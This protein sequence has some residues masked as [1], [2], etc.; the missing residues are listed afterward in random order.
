MKKIRAV[1]AILICIPVVLL[2]SCK[3]NYNGAELKIGVS[4][5]QGVFNPF[6]AE[7]EADRQVVSQMFKSIQ[8]KNGNN[9]L[10][11]YGGGI[12]YEFVG[13]TQVKYT[14]SINENLRFSNGKNV[15]IDDVIFFYHFIADAT[16]DGTY[17]D[18]YLN[19]IVGLKEYYFDDKNYQSSISDIESRIN[20]NYTLTTIETDDYVDYLVATRLE[21]KFNGKLDSASPYGVTWEEY[22]KSHG[23]S[24]AISDLGGNPSSGNVVKLV[25]T[26]E[27]E[28]NPLSYNPEDWYRQKLYSEYI[29]KNYANGIDVE[30]I[31]GIKKV[32]DYTC[33]VLFNSRNINALA[34][35]NALLVSK[36]YLGVEYIKGAAD[37]IKEMNGYDV[38]SGSYIVTEYAD[39][40]VSMVSSN[41]SG[42]GLCEFSNLK[43]VEMSENDD[44]VKLVTSGKIDVAQ[45]LATAKTINSLSNKN[46]KYF[47]E[48]KDSYVSLFLNTRKLDPSARKAL[49]GL[50]NVNNAVEK[51]IG[52]YYTRPLRPISVRFEE[53]PSDVTSPYYSESA[54]TV[55]NMGSG[56][57]VSQVSV[58]CCCDE[59]DLEYIALTAY[60]EILSQKGITLNIVIA[61]KTELEN[62]V[63]AG[64]ADMWVESVSDGDSCDKYNYYNSSGSFNKT[65]IGTPEINTLTQSIRS[66][67]GFSD[68]IKMTAQLMELVMEQAVECPLY[69]LQTVTLYNTE[70]INEDSLNQNA[71]IDGYA[72]YIPFLKKN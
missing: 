27:A 50:C 22:L 7:S 72:Y 42:E 59:K 41:F 10:I 4:G 68:K 28:T 8:Y 14:V 67:V 64:K 13:D 32:N 34:Q 30:S 23:Y 26:A 5:L 24:E 56:T 55:Y 51:E 66:A 40:V 63:I 29:K 38:C 2:S 39:G 69:Q 52:S 11:N 25:A 35:L 44:P 1:I 16:Y 20:A 70:V 54:F 36:E 46:V 43:F 62:A 19:D 15:T 57:K 9:K 60:K 53:Y 37:K 6:Y 21:E 12:S 3:S 47:I 31:S 17:S 58:Y 33:T 65:G 48:N 18:W 61:D 49:V 71:N 45:T